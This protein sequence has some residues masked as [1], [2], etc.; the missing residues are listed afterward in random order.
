MLMEN[1]YDFD[2]SFIEKRQNKDCDNA[3]LRVVSR[4]IKEQ[5]RIN[6]FINNIP[7]LGIEAK[8]FYTG[9]LS[10][11]YSKSLFPAFKEIYRDYYGKPFE[12]ES[13]FR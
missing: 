7:S 3:V 12:N 4:L 5:K 9:V 11:R 1:I 2:L 10:Q 8:N 6:E 13:V